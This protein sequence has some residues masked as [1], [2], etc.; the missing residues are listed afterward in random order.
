MNYS[1]AITTTITVLGFLGTYA[2]L[3]V[4]NKRGYDQSLSDH[5]KQ[6]ET[7]MAAH[8]LADAAI[9]NSIEAKL[10]LLI[11]EIYRNYRNKD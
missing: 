8:V 1:E 3:F 9:Q 4:R 6:I 5:F 10:D 2:V 7:Q 11:A